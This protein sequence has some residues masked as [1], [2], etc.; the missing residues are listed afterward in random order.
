MYMRRNES[1]ITE[2]HECEHTDWIAYWIR[3]SEN[4]PVIL[5][6]GIAHTLQLTAFIFLLLYIKQT[7]ERVNERLTCLGVPR[8]QCCLDSFAIIAAAAVVCCFALISRFFFHFAMKFHFLFAHIHTHAH[9]HDIFILRARAE[10]EFKAQNEN[11]ICVVTK[12]NK[13]ASELNAWKWNW[14]RN[15]FAKV[16]KFFLIYFKFV[17]KHFLGINMVAVCV[18]EIRFALNVKP[19][20]ASSVLISSWERPFDDDADADDDYAKKI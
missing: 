20:V 15:I 8:C 6:V 14:S 13:R 11:E 1:Q 7:N 2:T 16:S 5:S 9:A 12:E 4:K 18:L 3:Y 10:R 19:R 17:S